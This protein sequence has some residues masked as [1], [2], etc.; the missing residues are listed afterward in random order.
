M[1]LCR[2][3]P[4]CCRRVAWCHGA[5]GL[6]LTML[7]AADVLD[8]P[9]GRYMA[10]AKAAAD[11]IWQRGLLKKVGD[12]N[13]SRCS[14]LNRWCCA[15]LVLGR[16]FLCPCDLHA[17]SLAFSP[18]ATALCL[19]CAGTPALTCRATPHRAWA[20]VTASAA[21]ATRCWPWRGPLGSPTTCA[22]HAALACTLPHIGRC[23]AGLAW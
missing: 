8:D 12:S 9:Q 6:V 23:V 1:L 7:K 11:D 10:A 13:S 16:D 20:C 17:C 22:Q 18:A 2:L 15:D 14:T 3:H 4:L 21:T 5:A 19:S